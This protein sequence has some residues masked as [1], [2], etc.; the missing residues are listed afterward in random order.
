MDSTNNTLILKTIVRK[1]SSKF[2]KI[3]SYLANKT[4]SMAKNGG[5]TKIIHALMITDNKSVELS[6]K[7]AGNHYKRHA[8]NMITYMLKR[9]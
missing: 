5:Y 7:H 8:K 6:R 1:Q 3:G 4:I 9:A 2:K